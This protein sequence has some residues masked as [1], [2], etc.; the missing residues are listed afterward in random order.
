M[1][2]FSKAESPIALDL[3]S[4]SIKFVE[5]ELDGER[6][7]LK[8]IS[9]NAL[10][11]EIFS[12]YAVSQTEGLADQVS[13]LLESNEARG[14]RVAL[15]MPSPSVF[16]KRIQLPF[17]E[18]DELAEAIEFDAPNYIPHNVDAV[19]LD[20]HVLGPAAKGQLN[21]LLVAV[22]NEIVD[23]YLDTMVVAG[24]ETAVVDID[25]FAMQNCFEINYPELFDKTVA[26][27]NIG[28]RFTSINICK[29]GKSIF[30]GDLSLGGK[31]L[32]EEIAQAA[33]IG[34]EQAEALK[35]KNDPESPHSGI[36]SELLDRAAERLAAEL[37]R[38][39]S[40]FWNAAQAGD[41]GIDQIMLSGGGALLSG[42][43]EELSTK[44][45]LSCELLDPFRALEVGSTLDQ[46]YL[47]ELAPFMVI[48]VGLGIREPGDKTFD[49]LDER[50]AEEA[51]L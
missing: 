34:F 16:T 47:K 8:N 5:L 1:G 45:G 12:S 46:D 26:L 33:Q 20:F 43:I 35:R 23:S 48:A 44:T 7:R 6:Y 28:A 25:Y 15:A 17:Q 39:L 38:N 19:K 42:L 27:I 32:S 49:Y 10:S 29:G 50:G 3:G 41:E 22:K 9:M 13:A 2:L 51:Q 37:N 14:R 30:C 24:L 36:V 11:G 31:A 21:V 40:F 18:P 4:S